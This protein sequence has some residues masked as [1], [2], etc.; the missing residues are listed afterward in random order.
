M[1]CSGFLF[2]LA[3]SALLYLFVAKLS[4]LKLK[5]NIQ[6]HG[7]HLNNTSTEMNFLKRKLH[8]MQMM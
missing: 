3:I 2:F 1:D 8:S 6:I 5:T 4:S 7:I